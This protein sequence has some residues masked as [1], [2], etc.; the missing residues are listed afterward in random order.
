[1][2]I[3]RS[4][5]SG[6]SASVLTLVLCSCSTGTDGT[7]RGGGTGASGNGT[8]SG[9]IVGAGGLGT[10]GTS[11]GGMF[12][13]G[14]TTTGGSTGSGGLF[15]NTGG[16]TA[17]AAASSTG[18]DPSID[19]LTDGDNAIKQIDN[20]VGYW[21]DY[22][23][24][25]LTG[26]ITPPN[27][28]FLPEDDGTGNMAVHVVATG[29]TTWGA[30]FGFSLNNTCT[31]NASSYTGITFRIKG[32][33]SIRLQVTIPATTPSPRGT[34]GSLCDDYHGAAITPTAAWQTV[35]KTWADLTQ[36][37]WGTPATFSA[38][39]L[40]SIQFQINGPDSGGDG[41]GDVWV[42]DFAFTR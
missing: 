35:T 36:G 12:G 23:D 27:T 37:N 13:S 11:S 14:G 20:R 31:Y 39:E 2:T 21:Y 41:N 7:S 30:G 33:G 4:L 38:A 32:S 26:T 3:E 42:D 17:C 8:G 10:G 9:G 34:C 29:F 18:A 28:A 15:S 1:M 25:P 24:D 40:L 22:G 19:D 6:L 5:V 16:G